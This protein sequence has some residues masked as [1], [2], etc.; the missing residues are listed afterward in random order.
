MKGPG[1]RRDH[2]VARANR[3]REKWQE[4]AIS[5]GCRQRRDGVAGVTEE[6]WSFRESLLKGWE[7]RTERQRDEEGRR[8]GEREMRRGR[9]AL[10]SPSACTVVPTSVLIGGT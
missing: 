7:G 2:E 5:L 1:S 8:G 4:A 3:A 9:Q 10:A 6:R